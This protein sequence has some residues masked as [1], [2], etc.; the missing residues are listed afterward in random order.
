MKKLIL[1]LTVLSSF[2]MN[3]QT[4]IP[5]LSI[6]SSEGNFNGSVSPANLGLGV[7]ESTTSS[8]TFPYASGWESGVGYITPLNVQTGTITHTF[9]AATSVSQVLIWNA[10][11][12]GELDHSSKDVVVTFKDESGT[13]ITTENVSF[14]E[15]S[16]SDI[17]PEV[18]NFSSEIFD[19]KSIEFEVLTLW[20]GN[21]IS[22]RRLAY[23][24][25]GFYTSNDKL[26]TLPQSI[27]VYPNPAVSSVIIPMENVIAVEMI[28]QMG[29]RVSTTLSS[30]DGYAK[31]SWEG[32]ES[33][34]YFLNISSPSRR[35]TVTVKV[36]SDN[37]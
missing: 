4:V 32:I 36:V 35:H 28:D 26:S 13:V 11:F 2:Y 23:A 10:Y 27:S 19:V 21:E 29:R 6:T 9:E 12:T 16:D 22:L 5:A 24:G 8:T 17:L 37:L 34:V 31:L 1:A 20:G 18:V 15:A 33:G 25:S 30:Y 3:A 7:D 14:S